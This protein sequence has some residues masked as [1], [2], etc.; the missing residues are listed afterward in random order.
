MKKYRNAKTKAK[1]RMKYTIDNIFT[2]KPC[3]STIPIFFHR[4]SSDLGVG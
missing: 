2:F 4:I 1:M 3:F